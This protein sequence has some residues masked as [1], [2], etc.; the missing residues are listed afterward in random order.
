V[1]ASNIDA[2]QMEGNNSKSIG[3]AKDIVMEDEMQSSY[4]VI[5]P[6]DGY[7]P[8]KAGM[9]DIVL[10]SSGGNNYGVV[11]VSAVSGGGI[12]TLEVKLKHK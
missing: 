8:K 1:V 2:Y 11:P 4:A 3:G 10:E 9:K 7:R 6:R 5:N 12:L